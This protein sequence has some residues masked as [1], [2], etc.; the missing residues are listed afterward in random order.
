MCLVTAARRSW[1]CAVVAV[2]VAVSSCRPAQTNI[3][4]TTPQAHT[5]EPSYRLDQSP[6]QGVVIGVY[7]FDPA[8]FEVIDP[9]VSDATRLVRL[10]TSGLQ[11]TPYQLFF[12]QP[13]STSPYV[14]PFYVS[15]PAGQYRFDMNDMSQ[16]PL[17]LHVRVTEVIPNLAYVAPPQDPRYVYTPLP[18]FVFFDA[19]PGVVTCIGH[20]HLRVPLEHTGRD[21][22]PGR[23]T[24]QVTDNCQMLMGRFQELYPNVGGPLRRALAQAVHQ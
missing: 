24:F 23:G 2:P 11:S 16:Q 17:A 15:L 21:F 5:I 20:V 9:K 12:A 7:S 13:A 10:S 1:L 6:G 19:A 8:G 3:R 4:P 22:R 18:D 14:L